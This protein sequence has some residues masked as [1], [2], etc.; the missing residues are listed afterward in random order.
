MDT[1]YVSLIKLGNIFQLKK[2]QNGTYTW[3]IFFFTNFGMDFY[4]S[5]INLHSCTLKH[6]RS[7]NEEQRLFSLSSSFSTL[8]HKPRNQIGFKTD[9]LQNDLSNVTSAKYNFC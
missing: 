9:L 8:S 7:L 6:C 3:Q 2:I 1:K 4:L 5:N